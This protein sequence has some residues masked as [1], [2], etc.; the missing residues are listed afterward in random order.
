MKS[1][2]ENTGSFNFDNKALGA[3]VFL[4]CTQQKSIIGSGVE[5]K[6]M[7][8]VLQ[9]KEGLTSTDAYASL[10]KVKLGRHLTK[11]NLIIKNSHG[12]NSID[13]KILYSNDEQG[14]AGSWYEKVGETA[15]AAG[16]FAQQDIDPAPEWIDVQIK[17][18]TPASQGTGN[19][20]LKGCGL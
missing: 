11:A 18:T 19:A 16:V 7:P 8:G 4:K 3:A 2:A 10:L 13:Y 9:E 12:S 15:L 14:V 6:V 1:T 20:W 17:A 5:G